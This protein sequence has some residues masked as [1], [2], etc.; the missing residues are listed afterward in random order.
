MKTNFIFPILILIMLTA[1]C[2]NIFDNPDTNTTK[3]LIINGQ[4]QD[5]VL[6]LSIPDWALGK[7]LTDSLQQPNQNADSLKALRNFDNTLYKALLSDTTVRYVYTRKFNP[8]CPCSA[9]GTT[10]C[11]CPRTV[12]FAA[13]SSMSASVTI[14]GAP[15]TSLTKTPSGEVDFFTI[16]TDHLEDAGLTLSIDGKGIVVPLQFSLDN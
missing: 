12:I 16:P 14:D 2:K 1:G 5:T 9:G 13:P 8:C 7:M 3:A 15:M 4:I 10:C 11:Q 6:V